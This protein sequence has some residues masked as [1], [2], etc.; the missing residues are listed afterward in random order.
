MNTL[1]RYQNRTTAELNAGLS[2]SDAWDLHDAYVHTRSALLDVELQLRILKEKYSALAIRFA[3]M[4]IAA[5]DK[6]IR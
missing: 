4:P 1:D 2:A 3:E 6:E 5:P